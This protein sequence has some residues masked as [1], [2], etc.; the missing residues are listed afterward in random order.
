MRIAWLM[1]VAL[2]VLTSLF[3]VGNYFGISVF[4]MTLLYVGSLYYYKQQAGITLGLNF[5][6]IAGY[7]VLL[8][9][10]FA[11]TTVGTIRFWSGVILTGLLL[12]L[13]ICEKEFRWPEWLKASL[14]AFFGS[15]GRIGGFFIHG[16]KVDSEQKKQIGYVLLGVL[17]A[18]P[19]L[20][21]A[22][23][24]LASAD[25]IM[26]DFL[27]EITDNLNI[28][29]VGIWVWRFIVFLCIAPLTFGYSLWLAREKEEVTVTEGARVDV[30]P[31]AVSGTVLVLLNLLYLT[32]AYIQIR[33]LFAGTVPEGY[34]FADYARSGFFE[35]VTLS[36]LNTMGILTIKG[37]TKQHRINN[38]SLTITALCTFIMI[39]SSWYK[40]F[41][42]EKAYGYT[43][44]RLYVYMIL[45]YMVVFMVLITYGIWQS[46]RRVVEWAMII[47][48][49]YFLVISYVNVDRIIV[50]N[51]FSRYEETQ[52]LDLLY[53]IF[54][55]SEDS[56]PAL[57]AALNEHPEIQET[58][59]TRYVED[60]L[61]GGY[62]DEVEPEEL[63]RYLENRK[64]TILDIHKERN[65]IEFNLRH[66]LAVK[67]VE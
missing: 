30:I 3:Y 41:L 58:T 27:T 52:E 56:V 43:Q 67:A 25:A 13:P 45:A 15:L 66:N 50:E 65:I 28:D 42:Y 53:L 7:M 23:G 40:M 34:N 6:L 57:M 11:V 60:W 54:D 44:L 55:L 9:P 2:G 46:H 33:F 31:P 38:I 59:L 8:S 32:F 17:V 49:C 24:L 35:L 19:I 64:T 1:A 21:V 62:T 22:A 18:L 51:N 10:V 16:R 48:L 47:G 12:V 37:F 39:A 4:I 14:G 26:N 20:V 5:Y 63:L 36:I 29:D 61:D